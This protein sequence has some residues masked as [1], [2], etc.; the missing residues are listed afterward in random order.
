MLSEF[1]TILFLWTNPGLNQ[2]GTPCRDLAKIVIRGKREATGAN[3]FFPHPLCYTDEDGTHCISGPDMPDSMRVAI[4]RRQGNDWWSFDAWAYDSTGNE[5]WPSNP[6]RLNLGDGGPI[7]GIENTPPTPGKDEWFDVQG[8]RV[9]RPHASGVY[10]RRHD[11][12]TEKVV[13][14]K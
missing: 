5:S 1:V 10:F 12:K 14:V 13:Y 8:R 4:P 2:D 11:G 3:E 9:S 7:T 6:I